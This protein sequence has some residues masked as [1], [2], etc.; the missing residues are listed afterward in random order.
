VA[1][2]LGVPALERDRRAG[3][4]PRPGQLDDALHA[5]RAGRVDRAALVLD[6]AGDVA[7]GQEDPVDALHGRL[8]RGTVGEVAGRELDVGAEHLG[9]PLGVADEGARSEAAVLQRADD[10]AADRAGRPGDENVH[11]DPPPVGLWSRL[12]GTLTLK[13]KTLSGSWRSLSAVSRARRSP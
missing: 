8:E 3:R 11:E 9:G 5:S 12:G 2:D 6:L 7:A 1:L 4:G 10:M 13:R